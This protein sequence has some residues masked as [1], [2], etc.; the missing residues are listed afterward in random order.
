MFGV[1]GEDVLS[2]TLL[3]TRTKRTK[4]HIFWNWK[5]NTVSNERYFKE[6]EGKDQQVPKIEGKKMGREMGT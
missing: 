6:Q 3:H 2:S 1:F 5:V 4:F